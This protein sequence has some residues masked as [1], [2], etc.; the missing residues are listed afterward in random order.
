MLKN[1]FNLTLKL[2]IV[3]WIVLIIHVVLKLT[4]NYW[5]PYVIPN[6]HLQEISNFIDANRCIEIILNGI[7]YMF[8]GIFVYLCSLKCWWFKNK[9]IAI[10]AIIL[11]FLTY[12]SSIIFG[13]SSII[14]LIV[15]F[16]FPLLI[17]YKKWKYTILTFIF[18]NMFMIL[19]LVL[20]GFV[21]TNNMQYICKIFLEFDYYIM[22]ILNYFTFNLIKIKKVK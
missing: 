13:Q 6:N 11:L 12:A 8:N 3:V 21:N 20:E 15:A 7:L 17:D 19:S 16:G 4:F 22:L 1:K 10:F 14:T 18:S 9:K 5:Q 2:F